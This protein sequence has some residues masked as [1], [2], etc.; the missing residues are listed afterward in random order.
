MTDLN[1]TQQLQPGNAGPETTQMLGS[2]QATQMAVSITCPVCK[3]ENPPGDQYCMDCG[4]L[5]S[6]TPVEVEMPSEEAPGKL[7]ETASGREFALHLGENSVG[8]Q[9]SDVLITDGSVS[10]S[11]AKLTLADGKLMVEDLGSSNGT[12]VNGQKVEPGEQVEAA[13]GAEIKFGGCA[14][15]VDLAEA[16]AEEESTATEGQVEEAE[17]TAPVEVAEAEPI[18][19]VEEIVEEAEPVAAVAKLFGV[20]E[21][22]GEYMILPGENTIGRRSENTIMISNDPHVSGSH[23]SIVAGEDGF[24]LTDLGSTNGTFVNDTGIP[25]Q[26]SVDL[27]SGDEIVFGRSKFRFEVLT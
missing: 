14:M 12:F 1:Q 6:S 27:K 24:Q 11:H 10:R 20:G 8:R 26:Q 7:I 17:E 3:T 9:S 5:L 22:S 25:A 18:A 23:A 13:N 2:A 4:F 21:T 16:I 15:K 19:E